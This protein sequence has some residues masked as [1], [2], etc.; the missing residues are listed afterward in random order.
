MGIPIGIAH[1]QNKQYQKEGVNMLL[2][3]P[4]KVNNKVLRNRIVMPP[5]ATGK[6]VDGV[7]SEMLIDYY[8]QRAVATAMIIVEHEFVSL[9]GMAS[10]W[11][12]SMAEDRV[13]EGYQKLT[14][15]SYT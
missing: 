10:Q 15:Q 11:Q 8:K 7:P 2:S 14:H 6:S 12:L 13:I 1:F 5:M 9:E 3:E 4:I